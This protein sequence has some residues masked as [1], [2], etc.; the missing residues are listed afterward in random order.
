MGQFCFVIMSFDAD[1]TKKGGIYHAGIRPAV[2]SLGLKC[3][4]VD[5]LHFTRRITDEMVKRIQDAY[6]V[7]ADLS[8]GRPNCYY[9]CGYAHALGKPMIMLI[10]SGQEIHFDLRDLP[11]IEYDSLEQLRTKLRK[12]IL[13]TVLTTPEGPAT[14]D[15]RRGRFGRLAVANGRLLTAT[16]TPADEDSEAECEIR[17]EV[18]ALPR[19]KPL[20]G[21]VRFYLHDSYEPDTYTV[22]AEGNAAVLEIGANGVY[23]VGAKCDRGATRLEL[24]LATIPGGTKKFYRS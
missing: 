21:K 7:V 2:E 23:T 4:R 17:L 11:F 1:S 14:D 9:E 20:K 6:F 24:D 5:E 12:R 22:D 18:R 3:V 19:S 15:P 13:G 16:M 10:R 8:E